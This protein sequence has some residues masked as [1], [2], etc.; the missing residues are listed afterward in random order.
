MLGIIRFLFG[1]VMFKAT[2]SFPERFMNLVTKNGIGLF[3]VKKTENDLYACTVA[4]EYK[5]LRRIARKTHMKMRIQKK[6]GLPFII[7]K[8]KKRKGLLVG[9][10]CFFAIIY[11]LSLYIWSIDIVGFDAANANDIRGML[12]QMGVSVGTL[13]SKIDIPMLEKTAMNKFGDISWTSI[14]IKG[15]NLTVE[16]KERVQPPELIPNADPCNIKAKTDGQIIRM[17][18]YSGQ[19]EVS[20]GDAVVKDQLLVNGVVENALGDCNIYHA[21]AKI[22]ALTKHEL[23]LEVPLNQVKN[24]ETGK[25]KKRQ[26]IKMFGV[27]IPVKFMPT[28]KGNYKKEENYYDL[29]IFGAT[30]P[31][32]VYTENWIQCEEKKFSLS[33]EE[34]QNKAYEELKN[35]EETELKDIKVIKKEKSEKFEN[36][37]LCI[38][39]TYLCE[40]DIAKPDP[41]LLE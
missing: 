36:N 32:S 26:K 15:S 35:R 23:R 21:K 18:V 1:Y 2:G 39:V 28:P 25:I 8:Y 14:N 6:Y 30:L 38:N 22:F 5:S 13:K 29:K 7:K 33:K 10:I 11:F 12:S 17:E 24:I 4:S 19:K 31:I 9:C 16:L 40:E 37:K 20:I 41:I 3:N 27:N 34:A